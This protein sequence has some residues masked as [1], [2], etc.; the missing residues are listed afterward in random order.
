MK[1]KLDILIADLT[2][3]GSYSH[4]E[5]NLKLLLQTKLNIKYIYPKDPPEFR[6]SIRIDIGKITIFFKEF[7]S[8]IE[9]DDFRISR[10]KDDWYKDFLLYLVYTRLPI[11][12]E[13][14]ES[15]NKS[16]G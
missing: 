10:L 13:A 5:D 14:I 9:L 6:S 2:T 8:P 7:V 12:K 1:H 3:V 4:I 16:H 11:W 15:L